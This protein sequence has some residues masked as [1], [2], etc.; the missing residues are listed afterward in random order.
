MTL[1]TS[2]AFYWYARANGKNEVPYVMVGGFLGSIIGD[3]LADKMRENNL[4]DYHE[5][6][7]P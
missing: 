4:N 1:V 6:T 7:N 5:H 3:A 2:L